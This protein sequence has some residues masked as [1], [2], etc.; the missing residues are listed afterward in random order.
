VLPRSRTL[1]AMLNPAEL[2]GPVQIVAEQEAGGALRLRSA[3]PLAPYPPSIP[4]VFR[5]W[6]QRQPQALLAAER[7][8]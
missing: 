8:D 2:F 3:L 4:A 1:R 6:A 5:A 7:D